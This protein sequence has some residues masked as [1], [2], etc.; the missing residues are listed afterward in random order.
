MSQVGILD[1]SIRDLIKPD[2]QRVKKILSAIINFAKFREEQLPVF[3][4]HTERSVNALI[5]MLI[6]GII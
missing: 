6:V 1:F 4:K 3:D 5:S 2:A